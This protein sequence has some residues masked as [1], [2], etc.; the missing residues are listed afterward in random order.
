LSF[1]SR[2][3]LPPMTDFW[4]HLERC[5]RERRRKLAG[6]GKTGEA[7]DYSLKRCPPSPASSMGPLVHV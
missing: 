3:A 2:A 5:L 1:N 4:Q 7:I 6:K